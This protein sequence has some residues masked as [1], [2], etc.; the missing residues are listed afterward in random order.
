MGC[1]PFQKQAD[2]LIQITSKLKAHHET[3]LSKGIEFDTLVEQ[4]VNEVTAELN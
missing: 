2:L 3:V 1:T 4:L